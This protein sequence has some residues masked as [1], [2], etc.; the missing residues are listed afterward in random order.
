MPRN[1]RLFLILN[2]AALVL[3]VIVAALHVP[4]VAANGAAL[5][6]TGFVFSVEAIT[7]AILFGLVAA[8][9]WGRQGWARWVLLV[10]FVIGLPLSIPSEIAM[11]RIGAMSPLGFLAAMIQTVLQAVGFFLVFSD[12]AEP[13][14]RK[15]AAA[16]S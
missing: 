15:D 5:G 13:W 12:G 11:V 9:A 4:Q 16:V 6:G 7:F 10:L 2:V 8:V 14:F 3:G 1:V